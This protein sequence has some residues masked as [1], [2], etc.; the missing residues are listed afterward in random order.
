M[1]V[2]IPCQTA[3]TGVSGLVHILSDTLYVSEYHLCQCYLYHMGIG[4]DIYIYICIYCSD[5]TFI[6]QHIYGMIKKE[7]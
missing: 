1:N 4:C 3:M 6:M 2:K 7:L 5:M